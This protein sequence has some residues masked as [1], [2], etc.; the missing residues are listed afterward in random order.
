MNSVFQSAS[1][2]MRKKIFLGEVTQI[3]IKVN[4]FK[5][6]NNT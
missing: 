3:A 1:L 4:K 2:K 6:S 5:L